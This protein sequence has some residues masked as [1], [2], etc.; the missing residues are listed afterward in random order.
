MNSGSAAFFEQGF[1]VEHYAQMSKFGQTVRAE[2]TRRS[3]IS[4]FSSMTRQSVAG[5]RTAL[6]MMVALFFVWGFVTVLNDILIP[7]LKS[8]FALSNFEAM[9][10]QFSFFGAYFTMSLPAA[11]IIGRFGYRRSMVGALCMLASA[12]LLFVPAS[13]LSLYS[14]FLFA[15]FLAGAAITVLQVAA[16]PYIS[17]LGP[18]EG[19]ASRLNLAGA[20]NSLATT[21]GPRVGAALIFLPAGASAVT[22][23]HA[24][25]APY[26]ALAV[27]CL[28]LAAAL[29]LARLPELS[30]LA[31]VPDIAAGHAW[32]SPLLR[33]GAFAIFAYVGAEVTL[34]SILISFLAQSDVGGLDHLTASRYVSLYWGGA[35]VGRF[36]GIFALQRLPADR[37]LVCTGA[38]ASLLV[39]MG[40][41]APGMGAG[42]SI[43]AVGLFN[44]VM[45][46]CIFPMALRG[47][48][49]LTSEGSGIL[50][51]MVVGGAI[52]PLVQG[53]LADVVGY[54]LSFVAALSCYLYILLFALRY[55]RLAP[56]IIAVSGNAA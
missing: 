21:I 44:S 34:G 6:A 5:Y 30:T 48:G 14:A 45:W 26:I 31:E 55:R 51:M 47:L 33:W 15:L 23:A 25:R 46:P 41:T 7:H 38:V 32:H 11:R 43:V 56:R 53:F 28:C 42:W 29:V 2:G 40:I 4:S 37:V 50:V 54:R 8:V 20:F 49:S 17:A 52:I 12:L 3:S 24:V 16:N 39:I 9:L 10:V 1:F 35:M 27:I 36:L 18:P 22:R 13:S 19:A